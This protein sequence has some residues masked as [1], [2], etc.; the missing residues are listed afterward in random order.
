MNDNI[1]IKITTSIHR[2]TEGLINSLDFFKTVKYTNL[3]D[4]DK[5]LEEETFTYKF[6]IKNRNEIQGVNYSN[7]IAE[8]LSGINLESPFLIDFKLDFKIKLNEDYCV[9]YGIIF[10]KKIKL[11]SLVSW[12]IGNG[13]S[14]EGALPSLIARPEKVY[15]ENID[16]WNDLLEKFTYH[17]Y[18]QEL[19]ECIKEINNE[20]SYILYLSKREK[21]DRRLRKKYNLPEIKYVI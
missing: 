10:Y 2:S 3:S 5:H 14:E 17:K 6:I 4:S 15:I 1:K 7:K 20:N 16:V 9:A 18:E 13:L 12:N 8:T 11:K 19:M 21:I